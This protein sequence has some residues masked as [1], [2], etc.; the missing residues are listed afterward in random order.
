MINFGLIYGMS[1]FGLAANL[2][3]ERSAATAY[4]ERTSRAIPA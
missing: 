3:I 4:I 2:G 1:A